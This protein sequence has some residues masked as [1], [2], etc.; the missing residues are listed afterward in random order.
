VVCPE[1]EPLGEEPL[2]EEPLGEEPLGELFLS[3]LSLLAMADD[4]CA[5]NCSSSPVI[6]SS[7]ASALVQNDEE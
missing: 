6:S 2:G 5:M 1:E 3:P 4:E 7:T